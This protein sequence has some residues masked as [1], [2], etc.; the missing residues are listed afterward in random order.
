MG[1]YSEGGGRAE[2]VDIE[3]AK[4]FVRKHAETAGL[5]LLEEAR[6]LEIRFGWDKW[7][8]ED[9]FDGSGS[10]RGLFRDLREVLT[11]E[12]AV[13][14]FRGEDAQPYLVLITPPPASKPY[15][16]IDMILKPDWMQ[17]PDEYFGAVKK[18][19]GGDGR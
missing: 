8:C 6:L 9:D 18:Y 12:P 2:K 4:D 5:S 10:G 13:L 17:V 11:T 19:F 15:F 3:K 7:Y 14:S 1:Y 16:E